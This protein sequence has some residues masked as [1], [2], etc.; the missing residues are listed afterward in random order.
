MK[1]SSMTAFAML[2]AGAMAVVGGPARAQNASVAEACAAEKSPKIK[3]IRERGVLRWALG[4]AAPFAAKDAG[5]NYIGADPGSAAELAGILGV[6]LELKDYSYNLLPPTV[7]TGVADIAGTLYI[8]DERR[9][10]LDFSI[11]WQQDGQ[12]FVV[13]DKRAELNSI[14][15]LNNGNVKVITRIGSGQVDLARKLLPNAQIITAEVVPGGEAQYLVTGQADATVVD[16]VSA[17]LIQ[18]AAGN[19]KVRMIGQ[20]GSIDGRAEE[21]D[22]IEPFDNG[23]GV[24]KGDP[25]FVACLDA[26]V[27]EG[28]AADR[29]HDRFVKAVEELIK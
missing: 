4:I 15:T 6:K 22:L 28:V 11:P 10:V 18:K 17:P 20:K 7:A 3:E 24:A 26:W 25:G 29:F 19:E 1:S 5:N 14:D 27:A 13:L 23:F 8:T 2:A 9:K 12:L 21:G 16:A